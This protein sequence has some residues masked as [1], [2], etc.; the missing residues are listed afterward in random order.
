MLDRR[1]C[2]THRSFLERLT[3]EM[4]IQF[5]AKAARGFKSPLLGARLGGGKMM[6]VGLPPEIGENCLAKTRTRLAF[7]VSPAALLDKVVGGGPPPCDRKGS[8][9]ALDRPLTSA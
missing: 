6:P 1:K 2:L 7:A 9:F 5:Q 3:G 4:A 8:I